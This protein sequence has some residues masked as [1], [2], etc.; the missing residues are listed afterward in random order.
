MQKPCFKPKN[1]DLKT[2]RGDR[3]RR[4]LKKNPNRTGSGGNFKMKGDIL[5][6]EKR[7]M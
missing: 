6:R 5:K 2:K 1:S 7:I 3:S 4:L